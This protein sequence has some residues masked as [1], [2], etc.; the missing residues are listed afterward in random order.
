V[1][2][3]LISLEKALPFFTTNVARAL[4][5]DR[6]KGRIAKDMD[7]DMLIL[8]GD[9]NLDYVIARGQIMMKEGQLVV[10]GTYE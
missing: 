5:L 10:K 2:A 7:A 1:K 9:F 8:D 3:E 6:S 4:G